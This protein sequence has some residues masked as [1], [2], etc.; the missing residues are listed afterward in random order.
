MK[1]YALWFLQASVIF[2]LGFWTPATAAKTDQTHLSGMVK[3]K[4][5]LLVEATRHIE[6]WSDSVSGVDFRLSGFL[7]RV[8]PS[9]PWRSF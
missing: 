7:W 2:F 4:Q 3:T 5:L 8:S 6:G 1:Y 9:R